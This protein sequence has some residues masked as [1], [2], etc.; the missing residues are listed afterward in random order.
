MHDL[1]DM[2]VVSERERIRIQGLK[3]NGMTVGGLIEQLQRLK[4]KSKVVWY[5]SEGNTHPIINAIQDD[6]S[7]VAIF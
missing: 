5:D 7:T 6:N 2:F 4:A 1:S 3:K